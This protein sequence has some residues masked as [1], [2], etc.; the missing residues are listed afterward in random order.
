[1]DA[2][3]AFA[4]AD[5]GSGMAW[6]IR[7]RGYRV[8]GMKKS[9]RRKRTAKRR[10]LNQI[11]HAALMRLKKPPTYLLSLVH[12]EYGCLHLHVG[13]S[14]KPESMARTHSPSFCPRSESKNKSLTSP[15]CC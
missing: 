13:P 5:V 15:I 11:I 4:A 10:A 7:L 2:V 3:V 14:S 8:S 6:S 12:S 9:S 1:M